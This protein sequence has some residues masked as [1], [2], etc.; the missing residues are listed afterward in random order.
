[1]CWKSA[2][3]TVRSNNFFVIS[4]GRH[5]RTKSRFTVSHGSTIVEPS[6]VHGSTRF[7]NCKTEPVSRFHKVP[8]LWSRARFTVLH[9]STLV[10]P[11]R[12]TVPHGSPPVKP[13]QVHGSARF[14]TSGTEPD[15]RLH[16]LLS[17]T[18]SSYR[19]C[20]EK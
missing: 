11:S 16:T 20:Q 3:T 13:S 4:R 18:L 1:M 15:S 12:F 2:A 10:K 6:A 14:P 5:Q 19:L 17:S 7:Y 9:G 8:H